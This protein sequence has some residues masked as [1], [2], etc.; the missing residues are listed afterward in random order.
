MQFQSILLLEASFTAY[1]PLVERILKQNAVEKEEKE[2][3]R[4]SVK[5]L[6]E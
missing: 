5:D 4:K 1:I 3:S 2:G 6:V